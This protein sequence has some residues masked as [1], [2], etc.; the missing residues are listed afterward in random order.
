MIYTPLLFCTRFLASRIIFLRESTLF[1][2]I[3]KYQSPTNRK[4]KALKLQ[5]AS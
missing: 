3:G 4:N 1:S 2:V 5:R